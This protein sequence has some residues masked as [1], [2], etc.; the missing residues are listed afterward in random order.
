MTLSRILLL[1]GAVMALSAPLCAQDC[2]PEIFQSIQPDNLTIDAA[3]LAAGFTIDPF[4]NDIINGNPAVTNLQ[5]MPPCFEIDPQSEP[6]GNYVFTAPPGDVPDVCCGTFNYTYT[7]DVGNWTCESGGQITILCEPQP[8]SDCSSIALEPSP[9]GMSDGDGDGT[10]MDTTAAACAYVCSGSITTLSAPWSSLNTYTWSI[11]GGTLLGDL[12]NPATVEVEW[13]EA[14][15]GDITVAIDG[16]QGQEVLQ[17]C[18]VV[19]AS[20]VADFT[21]PSPV[22]L[23]TAVQ[24]T[25]LS[26]PGAEHTWDF[27]DGTLSNEVHPQHAFSTPGTHT[28]TLTVA[29]PLLNGA[30][31]TVCYCQDTH[32]LDIEVLDQPGPDIECVSTLCE[33]DSACYWTTSGCAGATYLWTVTDANGDPVMNIDGQGSPEICLLWEQG[34]FGTVSLQ[35]DNCSGVCD[36][37]TTVQVPIISSTSVISGPDVVCPGDVAVYSVPQWMDVVYD[38]NVT[39]AQSFVADGNQVSVIWGPTGTGTLTVTYESPFLAGLAEHEAPDCSGAGELEVNILP[40]LAFTFAPSMGCLD[41]SL[42]FGVNDPSVTW[43]VDPPMPLTPSGSSCTVTFNATGTFVVTA[44]SGVSSTTCNEEVMTTVVISALQP[45]TILGPTEGCEGTP[46]LYSV[47]NPEP[48]VNY[49]WT[50]LGTGNVSPANGSSVTVNWAASSSPSPPHEL[51]VSAWQNAAPFCGASSSL[52]FTPKTPT[53]PMGLDSD[54]A[55]NNQIMGYEVLL[56]APLNGEDL[57]WSISPAIAGSIVGGQ[58]TAEVFIQW[59]DY[60]GI[61]NVTV[62]S[63][64][65][66]DAESDTFPVNVMEG[67]AVSAVLTGNLCPGAYDPATLSTDP[68]LPDFNYSWTGPGNVFL[69]STPSVTVFGPG[70][71]QVEVID[72]TGCATNAF[73]EVFEDPVPEAEITSPDPNQICLPYPGSV[74]LQTPTNSGWIHSWTLSPDPTTIGTNSFY[75]HDLAASGTGAFTY[76]VTTSEASTGC[77]AT[78]SY[79]I[80][81]IDSCG[82]VGNCIPFETLNPT[83]VVNCDAATFDVGAVS[84]SNISYDYGD[85]IFGSSATHTYSEAGC[86]NVQ[87][88]AS[89]PSVNNPGGFCIVDGEVGVCI[90][91]AAHFDFE[92]S[93]CTTVDFTDLST[94]I[95]SDPNNEIDTWSWDFGDGGTSTTQHP[96]HIYA[97]GGSYSVQLTV[98]SNQT[99]CTATV[100]LNVI[101]GSVGAPVLTVT[102]P[103]CV[104]A[105]ATHSASAPN[106]ISYSW[107]FPDMVTYEGSTI[108]HTFTDPSASGNIVVTA[109]DFNG[110]TQTAFAPIVVHDAPADAISP[111]TLTL[112][113][114][115]GPVSID[116]TPGFVQYQWL[117]AN[118]PMVG[119]T[120]PSLAVSSAGSY[121]VTVEDANGCFGTSGPVDVQV[122]PELSPAIDGPTL[123]CGG[124]T[125]T[126]SLPGPFTVIK[127]VFDDGT[128]PNSDV[129]PTLDITGSPGDTYVIEVEFTD[130][131]GCTQ[132]SQSLTTVWAD[133]VDFDLTSPNN[134]ACAGE[135]VDI[136]ITPAQAHVDYTWNTGASST[137]ITVVNAGL[138]VATGINAEGCS[139]T[140]FFEVLPIPDLSAV[141]SG[142]YENCGPDWLCAPEGYPNYQWVRDGSV[143]QDGPAACFLAEASGTYNVTVT[144]GS[145]CSSTSEDLE[146]TLL[147]CACNVTATL[148]PLDDCCVSLSFDNASTGVVDHLLVESPQEPAIFLPGPDFDLLVMEPD[149][150]K[151]EYPG[152]LPAGPTDDAIVVCFDAPGTHVVGW[153]WTGPNGE[154][155]SDEMTFTCG[156]DT[157]PAD[158]SC[159]TMEDHGIECLEDGSWAYSFT[160]CNGNATPFEIGYFTIAPL[161]PTG[162]QPDQS[163]FDLGGNPITPGACRDFAVTLS[164]NGNPGDA[165]FMISAH[166]QDPASAPAVACCYLEHCIELPPCGSECVLPVLLDAQCDDA[167]QHVLEVGFSNQTDYVLGQVQLT[168]PGTSGP[169]IQWITGLSIDPMTSG[170]AD[171]TLAPDAQIDNPFCMDLVFY[172]EGAS[173]TLLECCH[174]E[175]CIDLPHCGGEIPGCTDSAAANFNPAATID[176]GS[177]LYDDCQG[178]GDP[179]VE[180]LSVFDPVCGCDNVTYANPCEAELVNGILYWT[181]GPCN[182]IGVTYGCTDAFACN[183]NPEATEEDGSCIYAW[184]GFDCDGNAVAVAGCTNPDAVNYN[185]NADTD[186]GSCLWDT[187]VLPTLINV[188]YPCT[189]DYNPVCGCDGNTYA[190]ACYAMYFGGVVSWTQGSCDGTEPA[191]VESGCAT[192]VNGDGSTTVADLLMVLGEFSNDCE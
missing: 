155:C 118:G 112:C 79:G 119:Q 113:P 58:G 184:D 19:G 145:G 73:I 77:S 7:I 98:G 55:C 106:A 191:P 46:L 67:T 40:E 83:A 114:N 133:E 123:M 63:S 32:V 144:N 174:I 62:V 12:Q 56:S 86:Y 47:A 85:G 163:V 78:D 120:G 16:P 124:G 80:S 137:A 71:H 132:V 10:T 27:G 176:D 165:C 8:V 42:A 81:V 159:F 18:V 84:A 178:P 150:V 90:P 154:L 61:A 153:Q 172:E 70:V 130:Q 129:N 171:F 88:T 65:C 181:P 140:A 23:E 91:L 31:D 115:D 20:P 117:D 101:L 15:Q 94:Y 152:G 169:I 146:F 48:G 166:A 6:T 189:E 180:C 17:Q 177:C 72:S 3:D 59:N 102:S 183:F 121:S 89:V 26:T 4:A 107:Q 11:N 54:A 14:G 97:T 135:A 179:T 5:G 170:I 93:E 95:L 167:G 36:L 188:Y 182:V 131:N 157:V 192:D 158:S 105:P 108:Q 96:T 35:I 92:I 173:G 128:G 160:L 30:G 147:D 13:G 141:P 125:A 122:F 148:T 9:I 116:A 25:S 100:I 151:L 75:F 39:G 24:F 162:M 44:T 74:E 29:S 111:A 161:L 134:P 66:G 175:W 57:Q 136:Q 185:S 34:P 33:G 37:A 38:W 22:C 127:W 21:A 1:A 49:F 187:C 69:G 64:I 52:T 110:C 149:Y 168:Y 68:A 51:V 139:H 99:G 43:S 138:Y 87:V 76:T 190:N 45:P 164:G 126:Y 60:Q 143:V 28:I 109:V 50:T 103:V 2:N 41:N 53:A 156:G 186:D 104:G 142:C 82:T